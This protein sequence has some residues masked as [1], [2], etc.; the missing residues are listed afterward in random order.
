M[1]GWLAVMWSM[2]G[3]QG[4]RG[5]VELTAADLPGNLTEDDVW[6]GA[7][8]EG[9]KL[10]HVHARIRKVPQGFALRYVSRLQI[11]IEGHSQSMATELEVLLEDGFRLS[12]FSFELESPVMRAA[13]EGRAHGDRLHVRI[14]VGEKVHTLSWP[15]REPPLLTPVVSQLIAR[16]D[17]TP[18]SRYRVREFDP[19]TMSNQPVVYE[20]VGREAI[21]WSGRMVPTIHLRREV[22]GRQLDTWV[23]EQGRMLREKL[24]LGV[25]LEREEQAQAMSRDASGTP[26]DEDAQRL[27]E[28]LLPTNTGASGGSEEP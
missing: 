8:F 4:E 3:G 26:F 20:V 28:R 1:C 16:R 10:G 19:R 23:D 12:S 27:F 9:R 6:M 13:M 15:L 5:A 14:M 7:Y 21:S 11:A 2:F 25:L 22:G 17:L 18:G 24:D